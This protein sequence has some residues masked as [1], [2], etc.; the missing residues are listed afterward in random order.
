MQNHNVFGP[1]TQGGAVAI[2]ILA[3]VGETKAAIFL[4]IA[5][6]VICLGKIVD[7]LSDIMVNTA[8]PEPQPTFPDPNAKP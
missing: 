5:L 7:L 6:A 1:T 4:A 3:A 8:P 2:A